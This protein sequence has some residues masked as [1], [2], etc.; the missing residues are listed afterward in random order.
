MQASNR[1]TKGAPVERVGLGAR[2]LGVLTSP[3]ET[4]ERVMA[5][6]RWIGI[7]VMGVGGVAV[8]SSALV[9]TEFAQRSILDQQ[10]AS[11]EASGQPASDEVYERME[12]FGRYTPHF[13]FA[14][15]VLT[16][17]IACA[18]LAGMLYGVG[19]GFL[20]AR[21]SFRQVF[22]VVAHAGVVFVAQ[23]LFVVPL[24]YVR[25]A[26]TSPTTLA[27][28]APTLGDD[29]FAYNLLGAIDLFHVWWVMILAI[30]LAVLWKRRTGPIAATLYG[31]HAGIA[32]IIAVLRTN[33]GF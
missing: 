15:V 7:L 20:G 17:P 5:D 11:M 23:Q 30:G 33:I 29:T 19:Y 4:F 9:S 8:L 24:N 13:T 21:A 32:L 6:P 12:Q 3:R 10:I 28:F 14:S 18:S 31:I 1:V 25:E 22:A 2:V 26:I 16:I 27:A